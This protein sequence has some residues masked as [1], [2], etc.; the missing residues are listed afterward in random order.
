MKYFGDLGVKSQGE[1][2]F[3]GRFALIQVTCCSDLASTPRFGR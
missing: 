2:F 1:Q 3:L